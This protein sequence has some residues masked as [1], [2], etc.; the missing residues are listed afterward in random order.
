MDSMSDFKTV[1]QDRTTFADS[2]MYIIWRGAG[3]FKCVGVGLGAIVF[4]LSEGGSFEA[5]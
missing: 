3:A 4:E 2:R 5:F 1:F